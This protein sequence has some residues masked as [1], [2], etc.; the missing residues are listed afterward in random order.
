[1]SITGLILL[2]LLGITRL[3]HEVCHMLWIILA[4]IGLK[5]LAEHNLRGWTGVVGFLAAVSTASFP[6]MPQCDG[7]HM[8][9]TSLPHD[10][11]SFQAE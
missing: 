10:L 8:S 1:M 7:H 11:R 5:S 3:F 4:T 2:S 6:L 9:V